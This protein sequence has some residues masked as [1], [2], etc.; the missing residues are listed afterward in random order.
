MKT[1]LIV[2]GNNLY[3]RVYA[4]H[5]QGRQGLLHTST[6]VPTTIIFGVLRALQA[7]TEKNAVNGIIICNDIHGSKYRKK[8]FPYYKANRVHKDM[9]EFYDELATAREL[10][11]TFG[12]T[13]FLDEGVE[14][15]DQVGFFTH[16]L[17]KK[18]WNVIVFSDDKDYYQLLDNGVKIWRP[19]VGRYATLEDVK[20]EFKCLPQQVPYV[21]AFVG[22]QKDN[23]PGICPLNDKGI[24]Q[25]IGFGPAAA[26]KVLGNDM[27]NMKIWDWINFKDAIENALHNDEFEKWHKYL[28][29]RSQIFLSLKLSRIRTKLHM[30]DEQEQKMLLDCME[31]FLTTKHKVSRREIVHLKRMLELKSVQVLGTLRNLGIQVL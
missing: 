6:G 8:L 19:C 3:H 24:M 18:G 31:R 5:K 22:Q 12:M 25:K 30:Y 29:N 23:I 2:D 17:V 13:Q 26:I 4:V 1:A 9:K 11:T 7:F 21:M 14:A 27:M 10:F 20:K 15:D 28:A 16:T